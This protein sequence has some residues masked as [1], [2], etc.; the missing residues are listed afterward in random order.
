VAVYRSFATFLLGALLLE[1]STLEDQTM[2][3]KINLAF[4]ETDDLASYPLIAEMADEL[5]DG[6]FA[7]EFEDALED[8]ISRVDQLHA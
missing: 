2:T 5:K 3:E 8:L 1:A 7:D 6:G 4:I